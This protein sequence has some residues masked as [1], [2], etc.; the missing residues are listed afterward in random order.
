MKIPLHFFFAKS[1]AK[2]AAAATLQLLVGLV[3]PKYNHTQ[4]IFLKGT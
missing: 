3:L 2:S 4:Q 1:R